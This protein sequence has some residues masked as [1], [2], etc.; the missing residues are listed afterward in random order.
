MN[1]VQAMAEG[2]AV[3][4]YVRCHRCLEEYDATQ[5][6]WC[7]CLSATPSLV[8][9]HCLT[10]SCQ[11][12]RDY[13]AAFWEKAPQSLCR[14]RQ[15]LKHARGD[16]DE[17]L[18]PDQPPARPFILVVEDEKDVR[19]LAG[20]LLSELGYHVVAASNGEEGLKMATRLKPDLVLADAVLPRLSGRD[21]C[22]RVKG[23]PETRDIPV[24]IMS[25]IFTKETHKTQALKTYKADGYLRKPISLKELGETCM[26]FLG[27]SS[28]R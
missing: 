28:Q 26:H 11:A 7:S 13:R 24:V 4:Y 5:S 14:K 22:L 9:P 19:C 20:E 23:A 1:G 8:C 10:C 3:A 25:G 21:M 16:N 12:P 15:E 2:G 6:A 27:S 17:L 18:A